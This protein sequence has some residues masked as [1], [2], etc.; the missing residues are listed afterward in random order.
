MN[1][2]RAMDDRRLAEIEREMRAM[3]QGLA[4]E[5]IWE[6]VLAVRRGE[7]ILTALVSAA[8]DQPVIPPPRQGGVRITLLIQHHHGKPDLYCPMVYCD[9]CGGVIQADGNY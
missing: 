5:A 7:Q 2:S 8:P 9:G 3:P 1:R 6:L 4:R